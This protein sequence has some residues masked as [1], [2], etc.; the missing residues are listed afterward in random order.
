MFDVFAIRLDAGHDR[1]GNP[2]R[3]F[4]CYRASNQEYLGACDEG[5]QGCAAPRL[6]LP[7]ATVHVLA[8]VPTTPAFRL[9]A[10]RDT[11]DQK[12]EAVWHLQHPPEVA[13]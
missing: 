2:R 1:N 5:Y 3:A 4:I 13:R 9:E 10:L 8:T 12:H 7:G 6:F 11:E